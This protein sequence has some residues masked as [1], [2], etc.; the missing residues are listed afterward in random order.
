MSPTESV[1][2]VTV[3]PIKLFACNIESEDDIALDC[4]NEVNCAICDAMS[5]SDCGFNGS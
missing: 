4:V 5:V 3:L 2:M 1:W